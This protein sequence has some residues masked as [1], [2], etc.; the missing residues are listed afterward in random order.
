MPVLVITEVIVGHTLPYIM[1][2]QKMHPVFIYDIFK[3]IQK[4]YKNGHSAVL[5]MQMDHEA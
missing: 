3:N 2:L 5:K 4:W 1:Y